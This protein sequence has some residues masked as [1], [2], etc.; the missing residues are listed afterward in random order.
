MIRAA[1]FLS[2]CALGIAQNTVT[3]LVLMVDGSNHPEQIPDDLA[4][5]H[6]LVAAATPEQPTPDQQKRQRTILAEVPLVDS[7]QKQIAGQLGKMTTQL[8]AIQS[9]RLASD[10]TP[11]VLGALKAQ[12]DSVISSTISKVRQATSADGLSCLTLYINETVK[13]NIKIYGLPTN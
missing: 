13:R 2:F 7:D 1:L 11:A 12:E 3:N 6:F 4:W 5:R 10:G 9:A 8:Q